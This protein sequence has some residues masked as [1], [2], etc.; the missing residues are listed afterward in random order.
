MDHGAGAERRHG[1]RFVR[2]GWKTQ[3]TMRFVRHVL[4]SVTVL[5]LT[6]PVWVAVG[7]I[8]G[9]AVRS[10]P[11]VVV[12]AGFFASLVAL[13]VWNVLALR[14][15]DLARIRP[16]GAF[17]E[18]SFAIGAYA[19][20]GV[21]LGPV[22][23]AALFFTCVPA[24]AAAF[25]GD[26]H[27]LG[28]VLCVLA[29]ALAVQASLLY[30]AA[31]AITVTFAFAGG[32]AVLAG[33]TQSIL[34]AAVRDMDRLSAINTLAATASTLRHWPGD[35]VPVAQ[36]LAAAMDVDRYAVVERPPQGGPVRLVFAWPHGD[37]V[38]LSQAVSCAD[39]AVLTDRPV[40]RSGLVATP[41]PRSA[42][43][44]A[45]DAVV[46]ARNASLA[47][48]TPRRSTGRVPVDT[49][50]TGTVA[51]LLAA[52]SSRAVL[53][54]D[55]TVLANT[56]ELTGL[57]NRRRFFEV[58]DRDIAR[59]ARAGTPLAV[60]MID[61]DHFKVYNDQ[62]GHSAGDVLLR[63]FAN[64]VAGAIRA[65]D[66]L[67][68]Y[69]GEEFVLVL[70]ETDVVG[71]EHLLQTVRQANRTAGVG[72]P[73]TFSAGIAVWDGN[74]AP[75]ELVLRADRCLYAAKTAGRDQ[76]VSTA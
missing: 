26:N 42:P 2:I 3:P 37:W 29:V 17:A 36:D 76:V 46:N 45:P 6:L 24:V 8:N 7:A 23:G 72:Q 41:V 67:A 30:P 68:R 10:L 75:D 51:A 39:E 16:A 55:L 48:V 73:V 5:L 69:G 74:E 27:L 13:N 58:L 32:T 14:A 63:R 54:D 65:Q 70:P 61:L 43:P 52:M 64:A 34:N 56:D 22:H 20:L 4:Q 66:L 57:A 33:G 9:F 28:G 15:G 11:A 35:L 50:Q 62:F 38:A 1:V 60:A 12:G 25:F 19:A 21:G 44:A 71:A 47:V 49:R 59:A 18:V 40:T 31:D 53:V